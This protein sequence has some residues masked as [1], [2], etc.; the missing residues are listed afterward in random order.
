MSRILLIGKDGQLGA[1]LGPVLKPL[2]DVAKVGRSSVD[3]TVRQ[4]IRTYEPQ[5]IINAAAY[6]AVDKAESEPNLAEAINSIAP[7]VMAEEAQRSQATLIHVSTD[8]VFDG[9][10][11]TPYTETDPTNPLGVYG[12]TKLQGEQA[13]QSVCDRHFIL[14]TAWVYGVGGTGNFVKTMLRVGAA[15]EELR[16]VVDQVGAPTWTGDLAQAIAQ[17]TTQIMEAPDRA[18][19]LSGVYHYTNSG[20]ISWYD[21]AE[22]IFDEAAS[23]GFPLAVQRVVPITT[24]EYPTAAARPA[25]SVLSSRKIQSILGAPPPHW[26][27]GLRVMLQAFHAQMLQSIS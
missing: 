19:L 23:L 16:V 14:R 15:R 26:R 27:R 24:A 13:V 4:A 7:G 3:L 8:Y 25:Y 5:I 21:F 10:K 20:A 18:A 11:N 1:E 9:T 12:K 6:T 17:L 2:G 22:S